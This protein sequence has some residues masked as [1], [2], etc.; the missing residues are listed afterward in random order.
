MTS[1]D[2]MDGSSAKLNANEK[3]PLPSLWK[4]RFSSW[5][6]TVQFGGT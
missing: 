3:L 4:T 1:P 5:K 2:A 6:S